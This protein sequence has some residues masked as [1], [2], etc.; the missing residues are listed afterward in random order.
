MQR[1]VTATHHRPAE[2]A[3]AT[4]RYDA[5]P[6]CLP[7]SVKMPCHADLERV[8][9][10]LE[11]RAP[12][13]ESDR[14]A[15]RALPFLY[16]TLDPTSYLVR[17]GDKPDFCSLLLR[18]FAFRHKI[19]GEG[20]RQVIA[21]HVAGEFLDLQNSLLAVAD[22]NVDADRCGRRPDPARRDPRSR[23]GAAGGRRRFL[24]RHA[25]RF[26]DLPRMGGQCR[27]PR[28]PRPHRPHIVRIL[29]AARGSWAGRGPPLRAADDPR[30]SSPTRSGSPRCTSTGCC[31]SWARRG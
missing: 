28:R 17:D 29:A 10:R 5:L 21:L 2:R 23:L 22:H 6:P 19:T 16:R 8:V 9:R 18:G 26:L 7:R 20:G 1:S 27:P 30:S 3:P 15:L 24:D 14:E 11:R 12:L 13:E 25:R 4:E 31:A